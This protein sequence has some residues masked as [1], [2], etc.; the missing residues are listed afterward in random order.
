MKDSSIHIRPVQANSERHN[1]R[2]VIPDYVNKSLLEHNP[3]PMVLDSVSNRLAKAKE[4]YKKSVG[5]RMQKKATPIR[6]AV[7]N[8]NDASEDTMNKLKELSQ[9]LEDKFGIRCFQ[10]FV[11]ADEGHHDLETKE[12]KPNYH[13]HM[14]FDF[15]HEITGKSLKL[16]KKDMRE[17]QTIVAETLQMRR[18]VASDKENLHHLA[19]KTKVIAEKKVKLQ[20]DLDLLEQ[21]KNEVR[22]RIKKLEASGGEFD[23]KKTKAKEALREAFFNPTSI[24]TEK[25]KEFEQLDENELN[26][27][28]IEFTDEL[29]T[30]KN[31][32]GSFKT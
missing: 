15:T 20:E 7:V 1:L 12:W 27:A 16:E 32:I 29:D 25:S 2:E 14:V 24:L 8:L 13:A 17:M 4:R 18:G 10:I 22:F 28:I 6:E 26:E 3:E 21:K 23:T 5:Q 11:H 19:Y 9:K 30:L 31:E